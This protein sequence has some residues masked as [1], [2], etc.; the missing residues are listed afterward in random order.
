LQGYEFMTY[1]NLLKFEIFSDYPDYFTYSLNGTLIDTSVYE[2]EKTYNYSLD[3]LDIGDYEIEVW[4]IGKD[5]KVCTVNSVF[6]VYS[7]SNT[8]IEILKLEDYNLNSTKNLLMFNKINT[9][10][11]TNKSFNSYSIMNYKVKITEH[12]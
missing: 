11:K 12:D 4:A 9:Y 1:G 2:S 7:L 10:A 6:S 8:S 3:G 5:K